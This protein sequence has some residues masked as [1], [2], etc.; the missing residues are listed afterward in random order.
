MLLPCSYLNSYKRLQKKPVKYTITKLFKRRGRMGNRDNQGGE[1][2]EI[3]DEIDAHYQT[4]DNTGG[5]TIL[6]GLFALVVTLIVAAGLFFGGRAV[7]RALTGTG[8]NDITEQEDQTGNTVEESEQGTANDG[9]TTPGV[10][11]GTGGADGSTDT[12]EPNEGI[13]EAGDN[14]P[15]T[16]SPTGI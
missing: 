1:N 16:G 2:H 3:T 12:N 7:Y 13:P 4:D 11:D 10:S 8:A 9:Q 5:S 15:R 14:L 6:Y